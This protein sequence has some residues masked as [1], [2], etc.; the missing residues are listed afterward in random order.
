MPDG[1]ALA[2]IAVAGGGAVALIIYLYFR[3]DRTETPLEVLGW[4]GPEIANIKVVPGHATAFVTEHPQITTGG[5]AAGIVMVSFNV[6][7][8][9]VFLSGPFI[10]A[11]QEAV[12]VLVWI[13]GNQVLGL[14]VMLG[15]RRNYLVRRAET[16]GPPTSKNV[17]GRSTSSATIP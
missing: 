9:L 15:W 3:P 6:M 12:L 8:L 4:S 2:I 17:D 10:S 5:F 11:P 16:G 13:V 14:I 7:M 1:M